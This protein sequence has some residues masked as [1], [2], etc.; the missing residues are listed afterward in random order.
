MTTGVLF[1]AFYWEAIWTMLHDWWHVPEA[2]HGLI[3]APLALFFV[4]WR[5]CVDEPSGWHGT[6]LLLLGV[7]VFLRL[8]AEMTGEYFTL[9]ASI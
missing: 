9:Q 3:L 4:W 6:G 7:A 8:G 1:L 2:A 5:G